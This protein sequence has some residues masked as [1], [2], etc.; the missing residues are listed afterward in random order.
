[1]KRILSI[2]MGLIMV[3]FSSI[4]AEAIPCDSLKTV[5]ETKKFQDQVVI[6]TGASRG[7]GRGIADCFAKEG[8]KVVLVGRDEKQL[9][10]VKNT[11]EDRGETAIYIKADVSQPED[12][13]SMVEQVVTQYGR[14]DVLCH[15]AG[16]YPHARLENMTLEEWKKV[17]DVNLTGTFLAVRACIPLM[18]AQGFG[19]IVVTSSISG[20]QTA[21]PG[22]S[23]YTASKGGIAGFVKTAAVELAKYNIYINAVEPG[24][25]MTEGLEA[26]GAGNINNMIRAIPLGRLGTP[27]DVAFGVMFLASQESNF[28][29]GQSLIIDGGQMLP[30][31]HYSEY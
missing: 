24:N 6:V 1:M 13:K 15:N 11:I 25:I 22:H 21:L 16:I 4:C 30:E 7:I 31:S 8:A 10:F 29:T 5:R 28:I 26:T 20:P 19:K 9:D 14:I 27:E 2:A 3:N 18:K 23:H 17:I 12:I